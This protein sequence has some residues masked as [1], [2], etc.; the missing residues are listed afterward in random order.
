MRYH[1]E[2]YVIPSPVGEDELLKSLWS[3]LSVT[4]ITHI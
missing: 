2:A 1:T 4:H 3:R